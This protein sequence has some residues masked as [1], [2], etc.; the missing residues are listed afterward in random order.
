MLDD[1]SISVVVLYDVMKLLVVDLK[2]FCNLRLWI[3]QAMMCRRM[4]L[5]SPDI[6]LQCHLFLATFVYHLKEL[7]KHN[8]TSLSLTSLTV[9]FKDVTEGQ[10]L[11]E[12]PRG[13]SRYNLCA[14]IS[15]QVPP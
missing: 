6:L 11:E 3:S 10:G 8:S 13:S 1:F 7:K 9:Y 15:W 5:M 2:L 12:L 14:L 4:F